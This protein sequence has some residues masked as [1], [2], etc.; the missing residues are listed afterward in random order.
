M[1]SKPFSFTEKIW[2]RISPKLMRRVDRAVEKSEAVDSRA[3]WI[4]LAIVEKLKRD[5]PEHV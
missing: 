3:A 4:R 1:P 5:E 2:P